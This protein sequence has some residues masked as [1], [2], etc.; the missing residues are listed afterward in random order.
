MSP[1]QYLSVS[2]PV[3]PATGG[4]LTHIPVVR[5]AVEIDIVDPHSRDET[6]DR[7]VKSLI[8]AALERQHG[9]LVT[10]IDYGKYILQIDPKVPCGTTREL[11]VE[12]P[13][14]E[15]GLSVNYTPI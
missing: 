14:Y 13:L 9:I 12:R 2:G 10:E 6:L 5:H 1:N 11:R 8:P 15:V 3:F 7:A 4:D